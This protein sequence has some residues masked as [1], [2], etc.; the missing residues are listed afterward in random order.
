MKTLLDA[1]IFIW[2]GTASSRLSPRE[3]ALCEDRTNEPVLS[4][5]SIWE[6]QIKLQLGKLRLSL[7][8]RE[9]IATQ[10]QANDIVVL[11]VALAHVLA[12]QGLPLYHKD[13]FDRLIIA[14]ATIEKAAVLSRDDAFAKDPVTVLG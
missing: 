7:S 12:L 14:Q 6:M 8:L 11:P 13:P 3:R 5:A 2:W 10:Q 9:L 1:H 4:V